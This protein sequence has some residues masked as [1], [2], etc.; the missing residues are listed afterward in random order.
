[1]IFRKI[2]FD[3]VVNNQVYQMICN[4]G[5]ALVDALEAVKAFEKEIEKKLAEAQPQQE[6][7]NEQQS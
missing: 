4:D 1:M 5:V 7:K 3:V 6:V 2:S